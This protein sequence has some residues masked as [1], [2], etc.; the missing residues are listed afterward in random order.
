MTDKACM[1]CRSIVTGSVC[2]VCQGTSLTKTW[3][4]MIVVF[5]PETSEVAKV[6]GAKCP[7]KYALKIK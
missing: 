1:N 2:P 4:G 5:D 6:I 3:E 7:G